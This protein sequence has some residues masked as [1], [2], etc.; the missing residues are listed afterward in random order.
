MI[1]QSKRSIK[2]RSNIYSPN[3]DKYML[4][5]KISLKNFT[6]FTKF[7]NSCTNHWLETSL[8]SIFEAKNSE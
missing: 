4:Y 1:Y 7:N 6:S 3:S 8:A 5:G 2:Y